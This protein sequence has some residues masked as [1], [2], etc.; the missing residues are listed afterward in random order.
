MKKILF[1]CSLAALASCNSASDTKPEST[2]SKDSSTTS[3]DTVSYAYA[4][5]YSSKFEMGDPNNVKTIFALY[6]DWENN[7]LENSKD[8]FADSVSMM[9]SGGDVM[10]GKRDSIVAASKTF[11]NT[12]GTVSTQVH[13]VV[14]LKSTDKN[15]DWVLVW[16]K[17]YTT[18][19]KGKKDSTEFQETWRLNKEGK[20]D[21][22]YQYQQ[23]K[24]APKK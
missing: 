15:E 19:A 23:N 10:M 20:A 5:D 17:E 1:L 14:P 16:F 22:L 11:R 3:S 7:T 6:K 12:L 24:P 9:F 21:L 18:D 2:S 4:T 13:A 8:K